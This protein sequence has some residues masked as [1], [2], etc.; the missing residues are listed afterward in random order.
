MTFIAR[1]NT[2]LNQQSKIVL[3]VFG[4]AMAILLG[5][6]D[7]LSGFEFSFSLFYLVP[8]SLVSW[9]IGRRAGLIV[10]IASAILWQTAN[11]LAGEAYT[12]PLVP[13]WNTVTRLGFYLI[14]TLLL[15]ELRHL[16]EQEKAISRTDFLT[17]ALNTRSFYELAASELLRARR[18]QRPFTVV[19]L[20]LDNFKAINDCSGHSAGD[21]CLRTVASSIQSTLRATDVLA[22]LGGDEFAILMIDADNRG[23]QQLVP[24]L[25]QALET[26][27]I[28]AG[29][30]VTFSIGALT[31]VDIPA[32]VDELLKLADQL[33]YRVKNNGKNGVCYASYPE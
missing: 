14:V 24:R 5:C 8:I 32:S 17:G 20:D 28:R 19:Y 26:E 18:N 25:K 1:T 4:L 6:V 13:L 21:A 10:S 9:Y 27:M 7:F 29:W 23:A 16:W 33:M 22:R 30:Q 15:S 12:N 11:Y 2:Y 3:L 31:C